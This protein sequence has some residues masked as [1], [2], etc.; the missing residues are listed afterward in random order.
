MGVQSMTASAEHAPTVVAL[1]AWRRGGV[2]GVVTAASPGSEG[3]ATALSGMLDERLD[4]VL[5]PVCA[6][7]R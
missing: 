7:Q 3:A 4:Q 5:G 6:N 1:S 2:M